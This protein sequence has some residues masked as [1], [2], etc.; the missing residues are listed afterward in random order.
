MHNLSDKDPDKYLIM[1]A[2]IGMTMIFVVLM[3]ILNALL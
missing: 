2:I 3:E 1:I